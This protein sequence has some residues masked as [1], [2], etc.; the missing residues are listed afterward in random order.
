MA[1]AINLLG[2]PDWTE[3]GAGPE[4]NGGAVAAPNNA[5]NGAVEVL[6][7]HPTTANMVFAGSVAG[8]VWR[9]TDIT[10]GGNPANVNWVPLTDQ[11]ESIYVGAMAF[12]RSNADTLYVGTGSYSNTFRNQLSQSSVGLYRT[13]SASGASP[14]W[15]NLG[16]S[17]FAG[18]AI[19]RI[20]VSPSNADQIIVAADDGSGNGGLFINVAGTGAQQWTD[21]TDAAILPNATAS[22]VLR[23]PNRPSTYYAALPGSGVF[24]S[25]NNG[26]IWNRID[27]LNTAI[28]GIGVSTNI[29]L[30]IHDTGPLTVLYVGVIDNNSQLS[31][32]FRYAEDGIDNNGVGGVDDFTESTWA[33]IGA[34][35]ATHVGSQ[36]F[37]NFAIAA[38]PTNANFVYVSGDRPPNIFRGDAGAGTWTSLSNTAAV[39]NTRPH[40]DSRALY[41]R[42]NTT[43]MDAD[44]GGIFE[45]TNP[46]APVGGTDRWTSLVGNIRVIEFHSI[47]YDTS[48]N[49]IFGGAQDNSSLI[50]TATNSLTWNSFGGGDGSTQS[51]SVPGNLRYSLQNNFGSF[52][53]SGTQLQLRAPAGVANF[54]GLENTSGGNTDR[55][56][57]IGNSFE[58]FQVVEANRF[59]ANDVM[60]GR[61]ALY[62]STNQGDNITT[63]IGPTGIG[64]EKGA[65]DRFVGRGVFGGRRAATNFANVFWVGTNAGRIYLRDET[66][67]IND[68][69]AG[70]A[71]IIA[72]GTVKD[73]LVDPD[74]Y[75]R[76]FVLKGNQVAFTINSGVTWTEI[77]DN[78]PSLTS[79][80]DSLAF[81]DPTPGTAGD[82][83]LVA[84]GLG[85]VFRY[86]SPPPVGVCTQGTWTEFGLMPNSL[87]HDLDFVQVDLDGNAANGI[88]LLLAGTFGRG[89]WTMANVTAKILV[90]ATLQIVG[91]A[92]VNTMSLQQNVNNP[93]FSIT[94][95][96]G[97]GAIRSFDQ[98]LFHFIQ[99]QGLGGA[100]TIQIDSN[101]TIVGG[102]VDFVNVALLVSG[103]G[104]PND[105]LILE[106]SSDTSGDQVSITGTTVGAQIGD[107]FFGAC[108]R[109]T[110]SGISSMFL[111][112]SSGNDDV[113]FIGGNLS[114]FTT[115]TNILAGGGNNDRLT[116]NDGGI[117]APFN[118]L[119]TPS[120]VTTD[121]STPRTF[122][123][124]TYD[125]SLE[126]VT[127]NATAG[128]NQINITPSSDTTFVI[129]GGAPT[130]AGPGVDF[131]N[132]NFAGTRGRVL[133]YSGPPLGNGKWEFFGQAGIGVRKTINF[134]S[135]EKLNY[136]PILAVGSD[137][138]TTSRPVINIY[139]AETGELQNVTPLLAYESSYRQGVRVTTGDLNGDGI[140]EIVTAP[141]KSHSQEV[142]V[143]DLLSQTEIVAFRTLAYPATRNSDG[144]N[145]AVG[146]VDGD[147][148]NDIVTVN[149][150]SVSEVRVFK[151]S[152][153]SPDPIV[154][155]PI[156]RFNA[157]P[158]SFIGGSTIATAN[159]L[160]SA[161]ADVIV[162]SGSGMRATVRVF[163]VT[164]F[165]AGTL[166]PPVARTYFPFE[167]AFRG[168]VSVAAGD[169]NDDGFADIV[170]GAGQGGSGRVETLNGTIPGRSIIASGTFQMYSDQGL[171]AAVRVTL[172]DVN[173]DGKME[174]IA[175]QGQD[176][177]SR[178]IKRRGPLD[179]AAV[180]IAIIA[181]TQF[182]GF[183]VG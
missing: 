58:S 114:A 163:D 51:Y 152:F 16:R 86:V 178:A 30:A 142:R 23:D 60:I 139:D 56:F 5:V 117:A 112:L 170:V 166:N 77:T 151:N 43:L 80:L 85:G 50:Q 18:L 54:D 37:N 134:T 146:D 8:G 32:V 156:R 119:I 130:F 34:A 168:G 36:G 132:V 67:T 179:P 31:G 157:F 105:R 2:V 109:L 133:T 88:G 13:T 138:G 42:N 66:G 19:R 82:G 26:T 10:G 122:G 15:E 120:S 161:I 148:K 116:L 145:V 129:N 125:A 124:V 100:D 47:A 165:G 24:R 75:T 160:G 172:R 95:S 83:T 164:T 55:A 4:N 91:N 140:P 87:V 45:L 159:I 104:D 52:A 121:P 72:A 14:S 158:T 177:R 181:D 171:N 7:N 71:A 12:D 167:A 79:Q 169:V 17:T 1:L 94:V 153:G 59:N 73:V 21:L 41:F 9:T 180:D 183:F 97:L 173:S 123:G 115:A 38:D 150:R 136:F 175:G 46:A 144:T 113:R 6:L 147:G 90:T 62:A 118:Y 143:F 98:G 11:N 78:I 65:T 64:G 39:T 155:A 107:N 81:V 69:T 29:E 93:L 40:A 182:G 101:G 127:L 106:D 135:I 28:V 103:G 33:V 27:N 110:K 131:L 22:D 49:L 57:A 99:F 137:V 48:A 53:R 84:G 20:E 162:G 92:G 111:R 126:N 44:D 25:D 89:A 35:P 63:V 96:D 154:D 174:I 128:P 76:A 68:R 74:D 149:S 108:G 141:G 102:N 70:L 61:R 3:Q 176:G